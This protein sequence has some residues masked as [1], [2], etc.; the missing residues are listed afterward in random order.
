[1]DSMSWEHPFSRPGPR[2]RVNGRTFALACIGTVSA[3]HPGMNTNLQADY[4]HELPA[5]RAAARSRRA[6]PAIAHVTT[7]GYIDSMPRLITANVKLLKDRLSSYLR[8]VKAGAVVLVTDR[9]QAVVE[10]RSPTVG[11]LEVIEPT[12][13]YADWVREQIS[14]SGHAATSAI[15]PVEVARALARAE[16]EALISPADRATAWGLY[17]QAARGWTVISLT[18]KMPGAPGR[19]R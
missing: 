14:R 12:S 13:L 2:Q 9:G 8:E 10:L 11:A 16:R 5:C 17:T 6:V 15:T 7:R 4:V 1:M 3:V 19:R 18:E